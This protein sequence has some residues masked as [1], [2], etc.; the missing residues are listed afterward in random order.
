[1]PLHLR[2]RERERERERER[3]RERERELHCRLEFAN[4]GRVTA[5]SSEWVQRGVNA[6]LHLR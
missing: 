1:M 5:L 2:D 3:A 6:S 4:S